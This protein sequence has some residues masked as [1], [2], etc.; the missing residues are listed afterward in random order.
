MLDTVLNVGCT[1]AAI[2]GLVRF[3]GHP[4]FA[5]DCRRRFLES[6]ATVVLGIQP[7]VFKTRLDE[8]VQNE[9]AAGE[10]ELDG[11][12]LER[13]A[14]SYEMVIEDEGHVLAETAME[15]LRAAAEAVY[16]SWGSDR[17]LTYRKLQ[18]LEDLQGTAV[19]VQ[20]MAFGN[21]GFSSAAGVA[22]SRDPS[23]GADTPVIEVMF[24]A[25]G[26]DVVSGQHTPETQEAIARSLPEVAV[27]L[28]NAL[29]LLERDFGDVQD[30]EFTI[31]NGKLWILQT[32]SAKRSP[33]AALRFAI[34][35]VKQG[36]IAP[37]EALR[38]LHGVDLKKLAQARLADVGKAVL[39]GIGASVGIAVGRAAFDSD[40]AKRLAENGDPVI[41]V[42]PDTDTA[43][44]AGFAVAAGIVTAV[45]GRTAHAA[46]V[47]RQMNTPCVVGC[48][49]LTVDAASRCARLP[50]TTVKEG[51]WLSVDGE[52]GAIYLGRGRV[53][54][55][56]P[57]AEIAEIERWRGNARDL[58]PILAPVA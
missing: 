31:E 44:V 19:T 14:A 21:A 36:R 40:S 49:G 50:T 57:D 20:A 12:A 28:R 56:R 9:G 11:E 52:T 54:L 32:R 7:A 47:A 38:R 18:H 1:S 15:Q 39:Q 8:L 42:R 13:L 25:Q 2:R 17:A 33:L 4:R 51:D 41:L 16:R 22:F 27:Q 29:A 55:D 37:A 35:F 23:T 5:F 48:A 43:D 30:V 45:G 26:E 46:L 3:T 24:G 6:F 53:V 34:S 58:A 10:R